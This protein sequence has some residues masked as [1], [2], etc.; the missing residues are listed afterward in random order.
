MSLL[1]VVN[2]VI[3]GHHVYRTDFPIG[4]VFSCEME[5]DNRHSE[6]AVVVRMGNTVVGHVPEGVCQPFFKLLHSDTVSYIK[7][8]LEG[9]PQ[10]AA[11]GTWTAGG[12]VELPCKYMLYGP[13]ENKKEARLEIKK[14]FAKLQ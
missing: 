11:E 10:G 1:C 7:C 5:P 3:K 2:A 12:G 13:M 4:T 9:L 6:S 14:A 8:S